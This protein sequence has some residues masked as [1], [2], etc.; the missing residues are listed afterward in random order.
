VLSA[1]GSAGAWVAAL[2]ATATFLVT[3][4]GAAPTH[5]RL[6]RHRTEALV[7]RLLLVDRLR[8]ACALTA[9]AGAVA[10]SW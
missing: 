3:A 10:A 4:A 9:L 5:G 2:G 6:A 7:A 1:P 8:L